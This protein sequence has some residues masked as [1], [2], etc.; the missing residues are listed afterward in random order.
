MIPDINRGQIINDALNLARAGHVDMDVA[1]QTLEYLDQEIGYVP[2]RAAKR[3]LGFLSDM[4]SRTELFGQFQVYV[5]CNS[6]ER[7]KLISVNLSVF[8]RLYND[9]INSYSNAITQIVYFFS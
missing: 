9:V 8:R 6:F 3:E 2:W 4:M 5:A 1:L 7:P